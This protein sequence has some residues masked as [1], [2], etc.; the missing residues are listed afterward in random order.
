MTKYLASRYENSARYRGN[1]MLKMSRASADFE[2]ATD[3]DHLGKRP[4]RRRLVSEC[5]IYFIGAVISSFRYYI[6]SLY[7]YSIIE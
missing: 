3:D 6:F 7:S 2:R 4:V 5:D 1:N